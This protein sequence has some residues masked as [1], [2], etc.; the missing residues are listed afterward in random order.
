MPK[1]IIIF[2]DGTGQAGGITFDE[3]RTNVYKLYRACRVGPDTAIEPLEQVAFYDPG[4]G[5][6]ADGSNIKLQWARKIYNLLSMATG[7]G[8]TANIVD[9]YAALIRLYRNGDRIFL[10]GFSRGAYTI[11]SLAGVISFCGVPRKMPDGHALP[12]DEKGSRRLAETAVKDVYQFCASYRRNESKRKDF[13]L[14]TRA[15]IAKKFREEHGSSTGTG[16]EEKANVFPYFI[17]AFDTV[18]ALGHKGLFGLVV[19]LVVASPF[20]IGFLISLL[21]YGSGLPHLGS[22]L[23]MLTFRHV[24][25][26]VAPLMLVG[27]A[28]VSLKVYLKWAPPL[29]GYEFWKRFETLHF[30]ELKHR[31]YDTTLNVNVDYAKHAISI[32]ENREDFARVPWAPTAEK[33]NKRDAANTLYF[34]QV[35]FPG[36]H[37]D[38]GGG[39]E[40]NESRLSDGALGW[41]LA[42]ASIIPFGLKHDASVLRPHPDPTGT[43]HNEQQGSWFALGQRILPSKRAVMHKSVYARYRADS[44]V[45]FDKMGPYRPTNMHD[46]VDF[47]QY[48]DPAISHPQPANPEQ[49][50]ADDIEAKWAKA[51]ATNGSA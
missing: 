9:C 37:A 40:E 27:A 39:Y 47:A 33:Q 50:V 17:G 35:W 45:L 43:Q 4:L 21:S 29:P 30:T 34:E 11:R 23:S 46:H 7:L 13:L 26:V 22:W 41:M 10:I 15:A 28:L 51:Q 19:G 1:N 44:V 2:S 6:P 3:V 42:A 32:D 38:I 8:I 48:C 36:V 16:P 24:F 20:I 18:A 5:S 14:D 25:V 49:C 12:M 31:F